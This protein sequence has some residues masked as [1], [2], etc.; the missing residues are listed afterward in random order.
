M[1]YHV[2]ELSDLAEVSVRTLHHYDKLG[3]LKARRDPEN[4]YRYYGDEE[5]RQLQ[6]ILFYRELGFELKEIGDFMKRGIDDG[7]LA[8]HR[9]ILV[10]KMRRLERI[11]GLI[12]DMEKGEIIMTG[13]AFDA[14]SME[15]IKRHQEKYRDEVNAKYDPKVVEESR[16]KT[17]KYSKEDWKRVMEEGAEIF[18]DLAKLLDRDPEDPEVQNLIARYQQYI[19][20]SFYTCTNEIFKGLG[21]LYV[22]DERFT[23]NIDKHGEGLALFLSRGIAAYVKSL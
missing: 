17:G 5:V 19:S 21:E 23:Q 8:K 3:I 11:I 9:K 10:E 13:K 12:D 6:S 15:E 14:F 4:G 7:L 1:R 22:S 16:R 18:E 20:D 2:K